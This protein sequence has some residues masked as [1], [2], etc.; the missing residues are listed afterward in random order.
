M[1]A[2]S[3]L[4]HGKHKRAFRA[5]KVTGTFD[6]R[7][8]VPEFIDTRILM[9]EHTVDQTKY[10]CSIPSPRQH[11]NLP[12]YKN[13]SLLFKLQQVIKAIKNIKLL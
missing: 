10:F 3:K 2:F 12:D 7:A 4:K 11:R 8:P 1:L 13:R 9:H 6:K 5:R